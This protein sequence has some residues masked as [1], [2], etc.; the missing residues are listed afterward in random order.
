MAQPKPKPKKQAPKKPKNP[1]KKKAFSSIQKSIQKR[2]AYL[3][4]L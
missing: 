3:D 1:P 4:S 2:K